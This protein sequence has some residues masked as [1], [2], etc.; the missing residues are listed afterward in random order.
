M[1]PAVCLCSLWQ[2]QIEYCANGP[3]RNELP[4]ESSITCSTLTSI[5]ALVGFMSHRCKHDPRGMET[6]GTL[7]NVALDLH[8]D[9][10]TVHRERAFLVNVSLSTRARSDDD[11]L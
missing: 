5:E 9:E 6:G 10:L 3:M 7:N 2:I 8:R 1:N 4:S 11:P